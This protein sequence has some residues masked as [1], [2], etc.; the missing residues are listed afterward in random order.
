MDARQA[1]SHLEVIRT[2]M[3]RVALYRRALAPTTLALGGVGTLAAGV[4]W[5]F[6]LSAPRAFGVYWMAVAAVAL[7]VAV[8]LMR[9]QALRDREV[10]WSP[11]A[12]R[13]LQA[14]LPAFT[15]GLVTG[16][17]AVVPGWREPLWLWWL[18]AVWTVLYGCALHAAGFFMPRGIRLFGWLFVVTGCVLL[19]VLNARSYASGMPDLVLAHVLM[20]SIFGGFHLAYG[21][22]LMQTREKATTTAS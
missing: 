22:Y 16:I 2:L 11:P 9:R 10:F 13:V 5:A 12:R 20:G 19:V 18:P 21:L 14:V 6:D 1:S 3:E 15:V 8:V 17:V 7:G 4:G